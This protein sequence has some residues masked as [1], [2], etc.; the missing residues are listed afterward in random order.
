MSKKR[1]TKAMDFSPSMINIRFNLLKVVITFF[2]ASS[3][4]C[5]AFTSPSAPPAMPYHFAFGVDWNISIAQA[6]QQI[7]NICIQVNLVL[8][9]N[10]NQCHNKKLDLLSF[11][12]QRYT[13]TIEIQLRCFHICNEN[14]I[15]MPQNWIVQVELAHHMHLTC[16][17]QKLRCIHALNDTLLA[18]NLDV[19][20]SITS[21]FDICNQIKTKVVETTSSK[22]C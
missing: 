2:I 13:K 11:Q 9:V 14:Y 15:P 17:L 10:V 1:F 19:F 4:N 20:K 3:F 5:I 6:F 21:L 12:T 18:Y 8:K 7:A 22:N 16:D